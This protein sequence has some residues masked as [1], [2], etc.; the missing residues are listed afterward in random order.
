MSFD[1][2]I[3][4]ILNSIRMVWDKFCLG[5]ELC[6]R[7]EHTYNYFLYFLRILRGYLKK[8]YAVTTIR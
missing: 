1:F 5:V 8:F 6:P 3:I 7:N 4:G 2:L